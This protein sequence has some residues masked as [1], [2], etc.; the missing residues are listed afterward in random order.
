MVLNS[1]GNSERYFG[2]SPSRRRVVVRRPAPSKPMR[3]SPCARAGQRQDHAVAAREGLGG[4][5]ERL[6]GHQGDRGRLRVLRLPQ[7]L[8]DREAVA[9]GGRQRHRVALDLDA[10]TGED[11]QR[12]VTAGRDGHLGGRRGEH[13]TGD[14]AGRARHLRQRRVLLHR[15]CVQGEARGAADHRRPYTV[16]GNLHRPVG[17]GAAD[18][19]EQ[20]A[21]DED[22]ALLLDLRVDRHARGDLVVEAGQAQLPLLGLQQEAGEDRRRRTGREAACRPG[23]CLREY[24]AFHPDLHCC[25]LLLLPAL[26]GLPGFVVC[27]GVVGPCEGKDIGEQSDARH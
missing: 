11:G 3:P 7:E 2:R 20:S 27:L 23:N 19:G 18:V 13:L 1:V 4:V 26:L 17:K 8:T 9:V 5:Q 12:V 14:G 16:C 6:G 25:R 21:G 24:V 10:H 22:R 15:E